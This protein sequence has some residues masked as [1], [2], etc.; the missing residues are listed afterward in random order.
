MRFIEAML[1]S[2]FLPK[3]LLKEGLKFPQK[4]RK[5]EYKDRKTQNC[6]GSDAGRVV[7][8]CTAARTEAH[9]RACTNAWLCVQ[10]RLAVRPYSPAAL[11]CLGCT[12]VHP[13]CMPVPCTVFL[14]FAILDARGFLE[15]LIFLEIAFK[16]LFS[17]ETWWFLLKWRQNAFRH[18]M[19]QRKI[20]WP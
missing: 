8:Q 4:W 1:N 20:I 5:I 16:V 19:N 6:A 10:A 3:V 18:K 13:C 2:K 15:P 11:F 9:D 12:T 7:H 17:I 14:C